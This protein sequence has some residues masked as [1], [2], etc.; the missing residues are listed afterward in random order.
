MFNILFKLTFFPAEISSTARLENGAIST[1]GI[2]V[3]TRFSHD[4]KQCWTGDIIDRHLRKSIHKKFVAEAIL[5]QNTLKF[6]EWRF[7]T[8]QIEVETT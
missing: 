3:G 7:H 8:E 2:I 5:D 6:S 4:T 1:S